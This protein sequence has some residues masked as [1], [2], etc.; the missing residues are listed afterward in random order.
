[1]SV[2]VIYSEEDI[3]WFYEF[4]LHLKANDIDYWHSGSLLAGESIS[5]ST[6]L[7]Y[8]NA[9]FFVFLVSLNRI[10]DS[11]Y[12]QIESLNPS[13]LYL[14]IKI[15]DNRRFS[16]IQFLN[17]HPLDGLNRSKRNEVWD[18]ICE[19]IKTRLVPIGWKIINYT[20]IQKIIDTENDVQDVENRILLFFDGSQPNWFEAC[21]NSVAHR[22]I[23]DV[24]YNSLQSNFDNPKIQ[25]HQLMGAG[26]E[27]KSTALRQ[28]VYE[29]LQKAGDCWNVLWHEQLETS[30]TPDQIQQLSHTSKKW[31]IVSDEAELIAKD[32]LNGVKWLWKDKRDDVHFLLCCRD[33]DWI[34]VGIDDHQWKPYV[35][36]RPHLLKG[37]SSKD[38]TL[39]VTKWSHFKKLGMRDLWPNS[40]E[41]A[42]LK[43]LNAAKSELNSKEGAFLG[44]M[45]RVRY[46]TDIKNYVKRILERLREHHIAGTDKTLLDAF[47]Y[48]AAPHAENI[49]TL[50]KPV[51][52]HVLGIKTSQLKSLVLTPLG[53]EAAIDTTGQYVLTRH[54]AIAEAA[55]GIL[56][57]DYLIS[58][59]VSEL[60]EDLV[61]AV[62]QIRSLPSDMNPFVPQIQDWRYTLPD[63]CLKTNREVLGVK[64][65]K[66]LIDED[67]TDP[68]I[69]QKIVKLAEVYRNT[70]QPELGVE[71]LNKDRQYVKRHRSYY[72]E[73]AKC[74]EALDHL[75]LAIWLSGV[76]L[77]DQAEKIPP[78][79]ETCMKVLTGLA[80]FFIKLQDYGVSIFT[81]SA[82]AAVSL[83]IH[84]APEDKQLKNLQA[85]IKHKELLTNAE[86]LVILEE[87]IRYVYTWAS[88]EGELPSWIPTVD[89]ITYNGFKIYF[90]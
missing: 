15:R 25:L 17:K 40:I 43:L 36:L 51:L 73:W 71:E 19:Q 76:A 28:V 83:G 13:S 7:A 27:G 53:T 62:C 20:S 11:I 69:A 47:A 89:D 80:Q 60:L 78:D 77:S 14:P 39:I 35:E 74:E 56:S 90:K 23:V 45:L 61:R 88:S 57:D 79:I 58:G 42:S 4:E 75:P 41:Q 46:G 85:A 18:M 6:T 65:L 48:I 55:I 70:G 24:I 29:L 8:N 81:D 59:D 32:L 82:Q 68:K 10:D 67:L 63:R 12:K 44:A 64:L 72:Y 49:L 3:K 33:I 22:E 37:L 84:I 1:M 52:A 31:L 26:G 54:R 9:Q 87:G 38:A 16:D 66:V 5:Q 50:Y 86:F 30:I 2:V 34:A 21:S